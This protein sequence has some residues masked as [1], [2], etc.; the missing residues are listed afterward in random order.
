M[1][2]FY[3]IPFIQWNFH[4]KEQ[5]ERM[6][7]EQ[8]VQKPTIQNGWHRGGSAC[9]STVCWEHA[10][11]SRVCEDRLH[12]RFQHLAAWRQTLGR[13]MSRA[14]AA[15]VRVCIIQREQRPA[16]PA[17]S[18]LSLRKGRS[19]GRPTRARSTSAWLFTMICFH[20]CSHQLSAATRTTCQW[21]RG[22]AGQGGGGL[23]SAGVWRS[24]ARPHHSTDP[25]V[26][27]AEGS[28]TQLARILSARG[29]HV[30]A[31]FL[32]RTWSS[33]VF[34]YFPAQGSTPRAG[35]QAGG[36]GDTGQPTASHAGPRQ[37]FLAAATSWPRRG[38]VYTLR[39]APC[40]GSKEL[41]LYDEVLRSTL[42]TTPSM[43]TCRM[44]DGS[45]PRCQCDGGD[46]GFRVLLCWH[47]LPSWHQPLTLRPWSWNFCHRS[48]ITSPTGPLQTPLLLGSPPWSLQP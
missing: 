32:W 31:K 12:K 1:Y 21:G 25:S 18:H 42:S 23:H 7:Q 30:E 45:K 37:P 44:R 33:L 6:F 4:T 20:R 15:A 2:N 9:V 47:R 5:A 19:R 10:A 39:T 38:S 41:G 36:S 26:R 13:R 28:Q 43:W 40:T 17:T 11:R 27:A 46:W 3:N 8:M 48:C 16:V 14:R 24:K 29:R 22:E 34:Q 35:V